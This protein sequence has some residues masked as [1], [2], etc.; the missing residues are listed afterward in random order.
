[1]K[2]YVELTL[3]VGDD[4]WTVGILGLVHP[5]REVTRDAPEETATFEV[6]SIRRFAGRSIQG[7]RLTE[8]E[9]D[10]LRSLHDLEALAIEKL[11]EG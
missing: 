5:A 11:K 9:E 7:D 3:S 4:E 10:L 6:L 8:E 2:E 1:M